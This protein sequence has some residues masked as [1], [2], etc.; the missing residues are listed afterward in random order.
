MELEW[1][2]GSYAVCQCPPE[3]TEAAWLNRSGFW[4]VTKIEEELS[5]VCLDKNIPDQIRK[6]A[7]WKLLRVAGHLGFSL[8][9]I[10]SSILDPLAKTGISVYTLSTF[11][12][13]YIMIKIDGAALAQTVLEESGFK[14]RGDN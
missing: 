11:S 13:D 10:L 14:F 3:E 1:L 8:V 12:T 6:E 7:G 5:I 4:S 9:S 2:A